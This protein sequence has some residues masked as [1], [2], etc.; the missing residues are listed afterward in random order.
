MQFRVPLLASFLLFSLT[1]N[2]QEKYPVGNEFRGLSF[3]E[4]ARRVE[5]LYPVTFYYK[6]EWVSRLA[7]GDR[8][9]ATSFAIMCAAFDF[10]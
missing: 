2:A 8:S 10:R 9:A 4:F 1:L 7:V 6:D 5:Q 3:P